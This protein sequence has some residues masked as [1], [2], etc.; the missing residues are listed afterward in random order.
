[1]QPQIFRE[2]L[3]TDYRADRDLIFSNP[4]G[5]ALKPDSTSASISA[6]FQR[7][8]IPKP[9]GAALDLLRPSHGSHLLAQNEANA[10]GTPHRE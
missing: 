7:L 10:W 4:D 9:K 1:M 2:Q 3:G 8:K 6:L 5:T